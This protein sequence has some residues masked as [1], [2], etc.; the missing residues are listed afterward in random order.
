MKHFRVK[1]KITRQ[2]NA[3]HRGAKF[4]SDGTGVPSGRKQF[5]LLCS[6][7]GAQLSVLTDCVNSVCCLQAPPPAPSILPPPPRPA[8]RRPPPP[9]RPRHSSARWTPA[10]P[11][12]SPPALPSSRCRACTAGWRGSTLTSPG[13]STWRLQ[14]RPTS[15]PR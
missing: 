8:R 11:A 9:A 7:S 15:S 14:G 12:V 4:Q 10:V 5:T 13:P 6:G 1:F 2:T 3:N